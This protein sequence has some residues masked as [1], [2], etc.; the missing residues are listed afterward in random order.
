MIPPSFLVLI[1]IYSIGKC[2]VIYLITAIF[3]SAI[4]QDG[5]F[6]AQSAVPR[7]ITSG[8]LCL[9]QCF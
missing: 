6:S 5:M 9:V 3:G 2:S 1:R 8:L 7:T 4:R